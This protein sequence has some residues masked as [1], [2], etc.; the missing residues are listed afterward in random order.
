MMMMIKVSY[1]TARCLYTTGMQVQVCGVTD[2]AERWQ[3]LKGLLLNNH[4][5]P[6]EASC[7][8]DERV[9][10]SQNGAR[11]TDSSLTDASPQPIR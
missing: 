3:I 4:A 9:A 5:R 6:R 8:R 2:A 7:R 10:V 1:F 11:T